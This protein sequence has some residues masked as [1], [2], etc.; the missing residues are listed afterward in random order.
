MTDPSKFDP[1]RVRAAWTT[2]D[3]QNLKKGCTTDQ[4]TGGTPGPGD[5]KPGMLDA[6][7][8]LKP[9]LLLGDDL[10]PSIL[11]AP[12]DE[13]PGSSSGDPGGESSSSSSGDDGSSS[14][15]S[16][17]PITLTMQESIGPVPPQ[18]LGDYLQAGEWNGKATFF[19]ESSSA[20]IFW[21]VGRW[22]VEYLGDYW[23]TYVP[24]EGPPVGVYFQGLDDVSGTYIYT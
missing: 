1:S 11:L 14:S 10:K 8:N 19:H 24:F 6:A 22:L 16:G 5:L 18:V 9:G 4:Y 17:A 13:I 20:W 15:S 23:E 12:I 2:P 21:D 3:G 7:G